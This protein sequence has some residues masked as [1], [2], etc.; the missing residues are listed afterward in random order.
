MKLFQRVSLASR[1]VVV[2]FL[3]LAPLFTLLVFNSYQQ[4]L[5]QKQNAREN[6]ARL[7]RVLKAAHGQTIE[8]AKA[9]LKSMAQLPAFQGPEGHRCDFLRA[10]F[11][12][13]FPRY[14]DIM[15]ATATGKTICSVS[16][17]AELDDVSSRQFF[18]EALKKRDVG[19]GSYRFD[20]I[21]GTPFVLLGAPVTNRQNKM[22]AIL[23]ASL[24]LANVEALPPTAQLSQD[25]VIFVFDSTGLILARYPDPEGW[26]GTRRIADA[27]I[28]RAAVNNLADEG[29]LDL[30]GADGV[31]R[32]FA[33]TKIYKT[34]AQSVFLATGVPADVAY[35]SAIAS[36]RN[37]LLLLG[38]TLLLVLGASWAGSKRLILRKLRRLEAVA[39]RIKNGDL[40]ARTEMRRSAGEI[41]QLGAAM[42]DMAQSI[43][44][45]IQELQR[46]G[47]ELR[48]LKEMSD[49]MQVCATQDEVLAVVRQFALRLFPQ[50]P[51]TLYLLHA[52]GDHYESRTSWRDPAVKADFLPQDCWAVRRGKMYRVEATGHEPRCHHVDDPPPSSYVCVP[53]VVQGE[54]L[55][56]LHLEN[57]K[58]SHSDEQPLA[59]AFAEHA[60][61]TLENLKLTEKLHAQAMR[62]GLTGLFNRRFMEESLL[63]ETRRA[64]RNDTPLSMIMIDID[65][66]KR[67]ND[68]FGHPA[69]D[70]LLRGVGKMLQ[71]EM[72][73]S[74]LAC[75]YGGEEFTI[76][77]PGTPL[78]SASEIAEKLRDKAQALEM[79]M[80]GRP[81]D[82][83]TISLGVASY[84]QHG[85]S[86]EAVL[87]AADMALL[88]AKT[89]R[90]RTVT[91]GIAELEIHKRIPRR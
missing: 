43:Q 24:S 25:S 91:Y 58:L 26:K 69:G 56:I 57:D 19:T 41:G 6:A 5:S 1:L 7:V 17:S 88:K 63:R 64:D 27:P 81:L 9:V 74:D 71:A 44:G 29:I 67:F 68:T 61:L 30:I 35:E 42:D 79:A 15:L 40:A 86:W 52:S 83:I 82:R 48:D 33:Y 47:N 85:D 4:Y 38:A 18:Q 55:G 80:D 77:L 87:H 84:P 78:S 75:R 13:V 28:I 31:Q 3:V 14:S 70:A 50:Q 37:D 49:A 72:R 23:Y 54:M 20:P 46:Y 34:Q 45:R 73:G 8:D 39:E 59:V 65:H 2:L 53:L 11:P 36:F 12:H 62:D 16:A 10:E 76:I 51:G 89:T 32:M 21:T 22:E 90:N 60:A 66:F